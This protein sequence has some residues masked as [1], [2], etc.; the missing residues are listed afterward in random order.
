MTLSRRA[1]LKGAATAAVTAVVA[2]EIIAKESSAVVQGLK[3]S[4]AFDA[5]VFYC[6]YIPLQYGS[7][8]APELVTRPR[9]SFKTRY[10]EVAHDQS[11]DRLLFV[12]RTNRELIDS[13]LC[14]VREKIASLIEKRSRGGH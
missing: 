6:P 1:F 12:D 7:A 5:G 3:G 13:R 2:P 11:S 4:T 14:T 10:G 9:L 8:V